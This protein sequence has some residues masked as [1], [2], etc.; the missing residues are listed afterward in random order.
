MTVPNY[1]KTR[2]LQ[3]MKQISWIRIITALV[4][5]TALGCGGGT[6][7]M[8]QTIA[9]SPTPNVKYI[10]AEN[11]VYISGIQSV[12]VFP[13]AD[14]SQQQNSILADEWGGNIKIQE[15]I[16]DQL[17]AHGLTVAIQEDVNT[18]LVDHDIIRPIDEQRYLIHGTVNKGDG[19]NPLN[20]VASPEY[21]L[22]Y[23]TYSQ[24][25]RDE[26]V[27]LIAKDKSKHKTKKRNSPVIQGATVGLS[28]EKVVELAEALDVDL[29]IRGRII[30][31][32]IKETASGEI[33]NS[34]LIPVMVR[35]SSQFLMGGSGSFESGQET[36]R[37]G[38][39]P[40]VFGNARGI[41]LGRADSDGYEADLESLNNMSLGA[42]TGYAINGAGGAWLGAGVG[43]LV[44]QQPKRSKRTA[45]MQV[46]IYAQDGKTGDVMWSNRVAMEYTPA[47]NFDYQNTHIKVMYDNVVREGIKVLMD[48]FFAEAEG[49]FSETADT[50]EPVQKEGT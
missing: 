25:M 44:A 4:V 15:A 22:A 7:T 40:S 21:T 3:A 35:G 27:D 13:F 14:Y 30:D 2:R 24:V 9:P 20:D 16:L 39:L 36:P 34:G 33:K 42:A 8:T 6:A 45:V 37:Q 26:I 23:N 18:L 5:L 46:R 12:A 49:V 17:I 47:S 10:P 19:D 28:K 31:Y 32:G 1:R 41:L 11:T 50:T 43:Y 38:L 29:I 48:G